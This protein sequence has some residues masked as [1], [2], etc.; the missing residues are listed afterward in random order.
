MQAG[1]AINV[2][3]KSGFSPLGIAAAGGHSLVVKALLKAASTQTAG[4][5]TAG[6]RV[7][8]ERNEILQLVDNQGNTPLHFAASSGE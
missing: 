7:V 5:E 3:N 6:K 2:K 1:S 4:S 8:S